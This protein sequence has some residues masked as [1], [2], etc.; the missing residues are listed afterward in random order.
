M[1]FKIEITSQDYSKNVSK[2]SNQDMRFWCQTFILVIR[3]QAKSFKIGIKG[4]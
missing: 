4:A 1:G 2:G 3:K